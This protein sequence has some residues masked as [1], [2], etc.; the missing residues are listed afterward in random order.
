MPCHRPG[1]QVAWFLLLGWLACAPLAVAQPGTPDDGQTR[2]YVG[3]RAGLVA[4]I[5]ATWMPD[6]SLEFD[7]RGGPG[8]IRADRVTAMGQPVTSL[9][10]ACDLVAANPPFEGTATIELSTWRERP[11]CLI[12]TAIDDFRQPRAIV[13]DHPERG[14]GAG[15]AL[16]ALTVDAA[17]FDAV[18]ATVEFDT[19][20]VTAADFLESAIDLIAMHTLMRDRFD[21]AEVRRDA[22][23]QLDE[24][25][26][27]PAIADT[28]PILETI[29]ANLRQASG[30]VHDSFARPAAAASVPDLPETIETPTGSAFT[31]RIG[32]LSMPGF[33]GTEEQA[34]MYVQAIQDVIEEHAGTGTCGQIVDLRTNGGGDMYPMLAGLAP[35]LQPGP[36]IGFRGVENIESSVVLD[37]AGDIVAEAS[38][39]PLR[40][41]PSLPSDPRLSALPVA[42]LIGPRTASSGEATVLVL[43][44]RDNTTLFGE[45]TLGAATAPVHLVLL[46]GSLMSIAALWMVGPNGA[47]YPDGITPDVPVRATLAGDPV[48][49][50]AL[51][52]LESQ[53]ACQA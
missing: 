42:V 51:R 30:D 16:V 12:E 25:S 33:A 39:I 6:H 40:R 9:D 3:H 21:W 26:A 20:R 19:S 23:R 11:A 47:I 32:Y 14:S 44:S 5:P 22:H 18:I 52:W 15:H 7:Y 28:H 49:T 8:F 24:A 31:D 34:A 29:I 35:F 50:A 4:E 17:H 37:P 46:D 43:A 27:S 1:A 36:L 38:G 10:A 41:Q 13:F 2:L 53:P 48:E 45:P